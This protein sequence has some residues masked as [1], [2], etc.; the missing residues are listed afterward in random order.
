MTVRC[1]KCGS[2]MI[3]T[4]SFDLEKDIYECSSCDNIKT[5]TFDSGDMNE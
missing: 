4:Y 1:S 5:T 2:S 3:A